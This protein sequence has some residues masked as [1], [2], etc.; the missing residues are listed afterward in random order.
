[1]GILDD[2]KEQ[3]D[4][5]VVELYPGSRKP[6]IRHPNRVLDEKRRPDPDDW[7][8]RP[9]VLPIRGVPTE[10]FTVGHL[11]AALGRRPVTIRAWER[12]KV[13]PNAT[14]WSPGK[15]KDPRGKRRLYTRAQ[16]EGLVKIA[17]EE[18]LMNGDNRS[19][20]AT[21]FTRRAFDLF[22]S[23]SVA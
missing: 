14:V 1:M 12:N 10:L 2:L 4:D 16:V 8:S 22:R 23:L 9:R 3:A 15:D 13:I 18:G 11:A 5:S 7:D 20:Q 19:I 6:I 21:D 17:T